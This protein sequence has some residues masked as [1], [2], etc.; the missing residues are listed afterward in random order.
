MAE[1]TGLCRLRTGAWLVIDDSVYDRE[2]WVRELKRLG[3]MAEVVG[4]SGALKR[5]EKELPKVLL[6]NMND[7]ARG[8]QDPDQ[9]IAKIRG[10]SGKAR[11][12]Y[13]YIL[14][15]CPRGLTMDGKRHDALFL[16]FDVLHIPHVL[17][18]RLETMGFIEEC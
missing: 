11:E 16:G 17:E 9:F 14:V 15:Y 3:F 7:M 18:M 12:R 5:C 2:R 13:V 10:L 4:T 6:L 1:K 8:G